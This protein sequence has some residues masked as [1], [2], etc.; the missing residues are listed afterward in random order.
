MKTYM[1]EIMLSE[2]D[3]RLKQLIALWIQG[4]PDGLRS[5]PL[6][7]KEMLCEAMLCEEMLVVARNEGKLNVNQNLLH[8]VGRLAATAEQRLAVCLEIQ[9]RTGSYS[10]RGALEVLPRIAT[11]GWEG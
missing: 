3:L 11:A 6:L 7:C 1:S 2:I 4:T 5:V 8:R 10:I 9:S